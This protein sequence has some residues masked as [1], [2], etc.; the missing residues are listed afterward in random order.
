MKK[1]N[2]ESN[3]LIKLSLSEAEMENLINILDIYLQE[4]PD[5]SFV[6]FTN[7]MKLYIANQD[8]E[9]SAPLRIPRSDM[10]LMMQLLASYIADTQEIPTDYF[11][12]IVS[13]QNKWE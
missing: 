5:P 11:S 7:R 3:E 9:E 12:E 4:N 10:V 2:N 6:Q 1:S 8:K 13:A